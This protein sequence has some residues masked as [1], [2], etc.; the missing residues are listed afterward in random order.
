MSWFSRLVNTFRSSRVDSELEEELRFHVEERTR[1]LVSRGM[2][3]NAA[4]PR[5]TRE[6]G[7]PSPY[8]EAS[9]NVKLL[10]WLETVG[11]D[12]RIGFRQMKRTPGITVAALAATAVGIGTNSTVFSFFDA[13]HLRPSAVA[14]AD[15][16]VAVHRIDERSGREPGSLS[17]AEYAYYRE[18]TTSFTGLA[19]QNWSWSWLS[20][21]ARSAELQGGRVSAN[22]FDVLGI[23]PHLGG[24]F[25]GE[26]DT[27]AV[28]LSHKL[29]T[30]AFD[31]DSG[32]VGR[33]VRID[34][35][36]FTVVGVAPR[37]FEGVYLGDA[38]DIW[39]LHPAADG[40]A[41]ARLRAGRSLENA[42]AELSM[43][44]TRLAEGAASEE[45]FVRV[46]VE[47]LRGVRPETRR[48]L[49]MFPW[50]LAAIS[51]C[52]LMIV[53]ANIA[54][55][56]MARGDSRRGEIALRVSLGASRT[57]VLRQ[58]VTESILVSGFGGLLSLP[59]AAVGCR[60]LEQFFGYQIP[61]VH[62]VLD[63]RVV[64][65]SITLSVMTGILFGLGPAWHATRRD[66]TWVM[67]E[68]SYAGLTAVSVQIAFAA[69]LLICAGLLFQS[70]RAVLL[71]PGIDA[72][73]IA[74]FRLR[75]SRLGYSLERARAYQRELLRRVEASP[76][77]ERAVIARVPAERGWCC[78]ID[79]A[80]SRVQAFKVG[81]NEV[82][83]G[84]LSAL[85]IPVLSGREFA[86]GD[87]EVAV[88]NQ[89]LATRLWPQE[90][91]L[92]RE[93]LIGGQPYRVIGIAADIHPTR[94]GER[95]YPYLYLPM[96][97]RDVR[98]PRLF[99]RTHGAAAPMLEQ[100]RGVVVSADPEVHVGQVSTLAARTEMSH[101][102][103]RLLAAM[104]EATGV[105]AVLLSAIGVYGLVSYQVWRRTREIGIR[106]ALGAQARQVIGW[107]V[108]RAFTATCVG[109]CAGALL[110]WYSARLLTGF[111]YGVEPTDGR[112][113]GIAI[114]VLAVAALAG[115]FLPA[116]RVARIDATVA[117][118]AP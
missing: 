15:R 41:V 77:V 8:M 107:I 4:E 105:V 53:C 98:D 35:R 44:G 5:A 43:L 70:T 95:D 66:L 109:L 59:L 85:G 88:V 45:R 22:Y 81:Q 21:G 104:L 114:G 65:L 56:L 74:H 72:Q 108:R 16:L 112:T 11:Q 84:F 37:D 93:L 25:G 26:R 12:V 75:P 24:F 106:L 57:R 111:L 23:T 28:V 79:V 48:A 118:R 78:E 18:H 13:I 20:N 100:L 54:G 113:F 76:G 19:V 82:S 49:A 94:S 102:Q 90:H 69:V 14:A 117:L 39:T 30:R 68:R 29:W 31:A 17:A 51:V 27:T 103:E 46:L 64:G 62:L 34:Q 101:Q 91:A 9:R 63:W 33:S 58:L 55:L 115:G 60:M 99:V 73:Q 50:L 36:A 86:D 110:A 96:W 67:R 97:G 38:L 32:V 47:P 7:R 10:P 61:G 1:D 3:R 2:P 92:G 6:L 116:R 87:R 89:A 40:V 52:L 83:P 42:R 80:T 71:R